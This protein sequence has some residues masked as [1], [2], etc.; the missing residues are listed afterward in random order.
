ME[1]S[2]YKIAICHL[3]HPFLHGNT[4]ESSSNIVE[5]FLVYHVFDVNEFYNS[6]FQ[7][8]IEDVSHF[9][10][11]IELTQ[12]PHPTIRNY[13][14]IILGNSLVIGDITIL[15]ETPLLFYLVIILSF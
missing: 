14:T 13:Q 8:D 7:N 2:K 10:N 3:Y 6:A 9:Y 4:E 12:I 15:A 11:N 1:N 5:H